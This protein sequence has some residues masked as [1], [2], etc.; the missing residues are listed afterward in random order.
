MAIAC[1]CS[2]RRRREAAIRKNWIAVACVEHVRRGVSLGIMQVC[3]GKAAPPRR[4]KAGDRVAYYSPAETMRGG[5]KVQAFTAYGVVRDDAIGQ[6][7]MGN[8][9]CPFRRLVDYAPSRPAAIKPLLETPDF[10]FA[11][12]GWGVKLRFGLV[13]VDEASMDAIAAA[14]GAVDKPR[15]ENKTAGQSPGRS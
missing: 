14:M 8:G 2:R 5:A 12:R 13:A 3:H 4:I 15:A 7:D 1:A 9:F 6:V 11:G 10:A